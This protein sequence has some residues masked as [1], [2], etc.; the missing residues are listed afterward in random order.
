VD[1]GR[2]T[3]IESH[4]AWD[5]RLVVVSGEGELRLADGEPKPLRLGDSE[6]LPSRTAYALAA[7]GEAPLEL[8]AVDLP[9]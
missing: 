7:T 2:H 1:A 3:P 6:L 8:L 9:A 5:R 4:A